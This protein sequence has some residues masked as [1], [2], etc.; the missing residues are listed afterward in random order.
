MQDGHVS[1][2]PQTVENSNY[3]IPL[4]VQP[5]EDKALVVDI[6]DEDVKRAY[7]IDVGDEVISVDGKPIFDYLPIILRYEAM[8]NPLTD[9]HRILNVFRRPTYMTD[10]KPASP[11]A[12]VTFVK[13]DGSVLERTFTWKIEK[14]PKHVSTKFPKIE[15]IVNSHSIRA[16]ELIRLSLRDMGSENPFFANSAVESQF[17]FV[18]V[19]PSE[20]NLS[21]HGLTDRTKVPDIYAALYR[22]NGKTILLTRVATYAVGDKV[23]RLAWYRALIEEFE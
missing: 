8:G 16:E 9:R 19:K 11:I 22:Y 21:K 10:L 6:L 23:E 20:K 14:N 17:K 5:V 15:P 4:L 3:L 7:G 2:L 18:R 1:L 13:K 12:T